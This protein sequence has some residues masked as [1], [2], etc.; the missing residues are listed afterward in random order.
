MNRLKLLTIL[1]LCHDSA[2]GAAPSK[3]IDLADFGRV[4]RYSGRTPDTFEVR[5]IERDEEGWKA[6]RGE[7]NQYMIGLEWD[8]PRDIAEVNIEFGRAIA[9]RDAIHLQ[10]FK[11]SWPSIGRGGW[12]QQD[13]PFHGEW[14]T[15]KIAEYGGGD[16]DAG[17][18]FTPYH[19]E[20]PAENAPAVRYRRTFRLRF[21]LGPDE[22]PPVR[23]IRAYG[24]SPAAEG[25]FDIRF[26]D[27]AFS[28]DPRG[29]AFSP[30]QRLK[31]PL[32]L[33]VVN[34]ALFESDGRTPTRSASIDAVPASIRVRYADKDL[35]SQTR[36][37]VTLRGAGQPAQ[38][39]SFL[40]AEAAEVGAIPVP[41][42]GVMITDHDSRQTGR[43]RLNDAE[44]MSIVDRVEKE[45]QQTFARAY[46]EIPVMPTTKHL[47][48]YGW[49]GLYLPLGPPD[50]R[51]EIAV[52]YD[53]G[54]YLDKSALKVPAAD[55][56]RLHWPA[57]I[58]KIH[59]H[60]GPPG[61]PG[62]DQTAEGH[63]KQQL[64]DGHLPIVVNR[65]ESAGITYE[66]TCVA[67]F[68]DGEPA[69]IR[70]DETVVLLA[71]WVIRN[72]TAAT[73]SDGLSLW[74]E[75]GEALLCRED[76]Q[77]FATGPI[78]DG[79]LQSPYDQSRHRFYLHP[80]PHG[81]VT[82]PM[83]SVQWTTTLDPG[84]STA[85][86]LAVPF[87]TLETPAELDRLARSNFDQALQAE[88]DRWR[89]IV[90]RQIAI[91]VPDPL[92]NDFYKSS[93]AHILITADRDP[94]DGMRALPAGT[95]EYGVCMNESCQQIRSLEMRGLHADARQ[96]LDAFIAGQSSIA[97]HGRFAG[98]TGVFH[99]L[100]SKRGNYQ[101]GQYN[102][103]H[104][105]AL[106]MLNEH[107]RFTRDRDWLRKNADA[108]IAACDFVTRECDT[109]SE[110]NTLAKDDT[111][112]GAGLLPPGHL[113]DP[114]E[115]LWWF[116][117]NAYAYRGMAATAESL[118]D[119][120]HPQ[121]DRIAAAARAFGEH[122]RQSCRESM[123]RAPVVRLRDG[124][125]VPHQPTRSRLRGR[126]VGWIRDA[127]YGPVHLI[128]CGIY[129][130][131]SPEAEWILRDA[132]D[133]VFIGAARGRTLADFDNQWF[134]WGGLNLQSN[135]L[136]NPSIYLR[137]GQPKHALRA[138]YNSLAANI[139]QDVRAFC[140]FRDKYST[141]GSGHGPI[142]KPPEEA[143]FF[144]WFRQLLICENG[145]N[146]E[147][148]PAVPLEWLAPGR[149]FTVRRAPTGFGPMDLHVETSADQMNIQLTPPKRNPPERVRLHLRR[150]ENIRTVTLNGRP[151]NLESIGRE[152]NV[153]T[154]PDR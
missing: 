146:L 36:T 128:D 14:V 28:R 100:P 59:A 27:Q 84:G 81:P 7:D 13:D 95:H 29:S 63:V 138:F 86:I 69:E 152:K 122:V 52:T 134:S 132:E 103:D 22:G 68:L 15:A 143:A 89:K 106:W 87:I 10:Y 35:E 150:P 25:T 115:W 129:A 85:V 88:A 149:Q 40:P 137:R 47:G 64:R 141:F 71:R 99:G 147:L 24:P 120:R 60:T 4:V 34:G 5:S 117:V 135:L 58:W 18:T 3:R 11:G 53:G 57:D 113:E 130:D 38:G 78:K 153:L 90:D 124:T 21:L 79:R 55:S 73:V 151:V 50:A 42:L 20:R 121:A 66:Q 6:W 136:P 9:H 43:L 131:D 70:G 46:R 109:P 33:S 44:P 54:I 118:A 30:A 139:Y 110:A 114:P 108:L 19:E 97:L 77:V 51:Q 26:D 61:A 96:Y 92:L 144:V 104:G 94:Y 93:L 8:E 23:H 80:A 45:P 145:P 119:I 37:I 41:A 101:D 133:N 112:W 125:Y 140:E 65:W 17:F 107:Y 32:K 62:F 82:A 67:T 148:L 56:E 126:D 83:R 91:E 105:Y 111:F 75:P 76:G 123:I 142:Y 127:L 74:I 48:N 31:P 39:L 12:T 154:L 102:L 72:T 116:A 49:L 98:K 16:R 2:G 1:F